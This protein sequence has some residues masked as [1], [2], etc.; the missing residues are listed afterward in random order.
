MSIAGEATSTAWTRGG[1]FISRVAESFSRGD[2]YFRN[3][4]D[5]LPTALLYHRSGRP[6]NLLQR[7]CCR[8]LGAPARTGDQLMVRL[9]EAVLAGWPPDAP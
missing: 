8:T 2:D 1:N 6:D 4:L 5:S 7:S 9:M 3:I